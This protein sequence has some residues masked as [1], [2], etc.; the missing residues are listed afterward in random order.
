MGMDLTVL[1]NLKFLEFILFI[2]LNYFNGDGVSSSKLILIG[3]FFCSHSILILNYFF[4]FFDLDKRISIFFFIIFFGFIVVYNLKML[5]L[6]FHYLLKHYDFY[7]FLVFSPH[8]CFCFYCSC[9]CCI[10]FYN[11]GVNG[12]FWNFFYL[13]LYLFWV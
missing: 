12:F 4:Y 7:Y 2:D 1:I 3:C 13:F 9:F 5:F 11:S 8:F 6:N 10:F